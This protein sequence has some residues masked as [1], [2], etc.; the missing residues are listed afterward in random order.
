MTPLSQFLEAIVEPV[1]S[2]ALQ[3]STLR[4]LIEGLLKADEGQEL[5][6]LAQLQLFL[7]PLDLYLDLLRL[8]LRLR[9]CGRLRLRSFL[10]L[11]YL[12]GL[13]LFLRLTAVVFRK[14]CLD[15]LGNLWLVLPLRRGIR[16]FTGLLLVLLR[17]GL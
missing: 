16:R 1:T 2:R 7:Q 10:L 14:W 9:F 13:L 6:L 11:L 15:R 12:P 8:R 3:C 17:I 5:A 4:V